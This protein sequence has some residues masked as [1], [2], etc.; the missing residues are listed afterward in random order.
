MPPPSSKAYPK[1]KRP[2]FNPPRPS[3]KP[4]KATAPRRKSAPSKR[5]R[6]SFIDDQASG[7]VE[8]EEQEVNE[9]ENDDGVP[10]SKGQSS[11]EEESDVSARMDPN[12]NAI[13]STQEPPPTIPP[14]LLTKLLHR[15]FK[16]DK[17]KIGKDANKVVGRYM[18]TFVREA[19]AR[20]A[21]ERS[22]AAG[23]GDAG[24]AGDFLEVG[25]FFTLFAS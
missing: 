22:E 11:S 2:Q 23:E 18:E 25:G 1:N 16:D 14:A 6:H 20:A 8:S 19:I 17:I 12:T 4:K 10:P 3:S 13:S 9:S 24:V 7:S 5:K 21:F 15:H